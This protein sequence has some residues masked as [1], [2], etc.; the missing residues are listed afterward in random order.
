MP[1]RL[2][3]AAPGE[4]AGA[5]ADAVGPA[6]AELLERQLA[7]LRSGNA[8][9][10]D[11][12]RLIDAATGAAQAQ[13]ESDILRFSGQAQEQLREELAPQLGLRP[14]DTPILDRGARIAEEATRRQGQLAL[15]LA[16]QN[17]QARLNFP[18]ASNQVSSQIGLS[19]QNLTEAQKQFQ[20]RLR[21]Q[22]FLNR[23]NLTGQTGNS[24]WA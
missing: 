7:I 1:V 21:Q 12:I 24:A 17:A 5:E 23:L 2:S 9:T 18:L 3:H 16:G 4:N 10:P 11:R 19:Q 8:A 20:S 22:A 15:G 13:G 14:T 6:Q